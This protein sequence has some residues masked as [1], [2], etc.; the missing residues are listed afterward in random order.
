MKPCTVTPGCTRGREESN[1][2]TVPERRGERQ[3]GNLYIPALQ[4]LQRE[5]REATES[6]CEVSASSC[7]S[8]MSIANCFVFVPELIPTALGAPEGI[9]PATEQ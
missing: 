6:S 8:V 4:L 9:P 3:W 7:F 2:V 5:C 1:H